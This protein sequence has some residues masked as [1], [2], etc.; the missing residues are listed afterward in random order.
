[1]GPFWVANSAGMLGIDYLPEC[2]SVSGWEVPFILLMNF[3][4]L[5]CGLVTIWDVVNGFCNCRALWIFFLVFIAWYSW[6]S[7]YVNTEDLMI[8][9]L[10]ARLVAWGV[11]S[12]PSKWRLYGSCWKEYLPQALV[13]DCGIPSWPREDGMNLDW[14]VARESSL[15]WLIIESLAVYASSLEGRLPSLG[16][17][18]WAP[19]VF[20]NALA[21]TANFSSRALPGLTCSYSLS[22]WPLFRF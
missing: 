19:L 20:L 2:I 15:L 4:R 9:E 8:S 7:A 17:L 16:T 10:A 18:R 11:F 13:A 1:M 12:A 6:L 5:S 21:V 14:G 3:W 22:D